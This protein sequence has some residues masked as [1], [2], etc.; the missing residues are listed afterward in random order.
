[1]TNSSFVKPFGLFKQL[2]LASKQSAILKTYF[3]PKSKLRQYASKLNLKAETFF[4]V[5]G[6]PSGV[7]T[8]Q[9]TLAT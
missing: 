8:T 6:Y 7:A 4:P 5:G 9:W 1:M 3:I 2:Q